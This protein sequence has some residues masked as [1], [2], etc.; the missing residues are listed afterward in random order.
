MTQVTLLNF[1]GGSR[2]HPP[3]HAENDYPAAWTPPE[4]IRIPGVRF[5]PEVPDKECNKCPYA[6]WGHPYI[7]DPKRTKETGAE[8]YQ[9]L[10]T[11]DCLKEGILLKR[12][13]ASGWYKLL[14][15]SPEKR[16]K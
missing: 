9:F 8:T 16:Q 3:R 6:A 15:D 4:H 2:P 14:S 10:C 5:A 11:K 7:L 13:E 1:F 12:D